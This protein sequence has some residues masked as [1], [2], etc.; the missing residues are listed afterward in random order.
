MCL[1]KSLDVFWKT[2]KTFLQISIYFCISS[3]NCNAVLSN[4]A[5]LINL[6]LSVKKDFML[7]LMPKLGDYSDSHRRQVPF[8]HNTKHQN[9]PCPDG[10]S[11]Q[12]N[13]TTLTSN[14]SHQEETAQVP[15]WTGKISFSHYIILM[16]AECFCG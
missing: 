6:E 5:I 15:L 13:L 3:L 2:D 10:N 9:L 12:T 11:E 1:T 4:V 14:I 8:E 16:T 7:A